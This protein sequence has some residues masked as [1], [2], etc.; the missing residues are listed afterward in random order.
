MTKLQPLYSLDWERCEK[1]KHAF[2]VF[3][4]LSRTLTDSYR[5]LEVQ[6]ARLTQ[7]LAAARSERLKALIEKEKLA[8]RLARLLEVLPGGVI[9]LDGESRIV[10]C[11]S[12]AAELLGEP[13]AGELWTTVSSRSLAAG[14]NP[15]E[16]RLKNGRTV[17][18]SARP[19]EDEPGQILLL[20]DLTEMR[21]LQELLDQHR[22]LA[23]MGEVVARL[24]HQV[25]T[26]LAAALLYATQLASGR[27]GAEQ[28]QRF[29]G[30]LIE[31]L[32]HLDRQV[33]DLL[34][35]S[36][37][38]YF[39][40]ETVSVASFL[41]RL[42]E[43]AEPRLAAASVSISFIDLTSGASFRGNPEALEGAF[44][45]LFTNAL[46]AIAGQGRI[47]V[48]AE[49][50]GNQIRLSVVDDGPGM[51]ESVRKRIFEPFF[52]TRPNGTGLGLAVVDSIVRAHDGHI[53]CNAAP[54]QGTAF[55]VYLPSAVEDVPLPGGYQQAVA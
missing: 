15:H 33:N 24:V 37:K 44:L 17:N 40:K 43:V 52:T 10:E 7:E 19:L 55:H 2:E 4:Q 16:R 8:N 50:E 1:L 31:R 53:C 5:E 36:R 41:K 6:V 35:F 32:H 12:V 38:G 45:N 42:K 25:R 23:A 30:K 14:D 51:D 18:I 34:L 29:T 22:R 39:T 26:P 47:E 20:T 21:A 9:V 27:L 28:R 49:R 3:N 46:D 54:G 11:N 48:R 13:L